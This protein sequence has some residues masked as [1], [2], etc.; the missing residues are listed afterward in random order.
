MRL[1]SASKHST[2]V[3]VEPVNADDVARVSEFHDAA[4]HQLRKGQSFVSLWREAVGWPMPAFQVATFSSMP[5]ASPRGGAA[6]L[7]GVDCSLWPGP[8]HYE[9]NKLHINK[10]EL[11]H[12]GK[13][14]KATV[15]PTYTIAAT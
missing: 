1:Q 3:W 5:E 13:P 6:A 12:I 8:K 4:Q 11:A 10:L 7:P 15:A 9:H 2:V 14:T